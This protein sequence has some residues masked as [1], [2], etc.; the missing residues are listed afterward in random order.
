MEFEPKPT[1]QLVEMYLSLEIEGEVTWPELSRGQASELEEVSA[2]GESFV[3]QVLNGE[4]NPATGQEE[5]SNLYQ[6]FSENNMD[7]AETVKYAELFTLAKVWISHSIHLLKKLGPFGEGIT[8][9]QEKAA[10]L[11]ME[12]DL[13][14]GFPSSLNFGH[15]SRCLIG[16]G[17]KDQAFKLINKFEGEVVLVRN[18]KEGRKVLQILGEKDEKNLNEG[19]GFIDDANRNNSRLQ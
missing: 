17:K 16:A 2:R 14:A 1:E 3:S 7:V 12:M 15:I 19:I 9:A 18:Q 5:V 8:D 4:L 10:R 11:L 6:S 13:H